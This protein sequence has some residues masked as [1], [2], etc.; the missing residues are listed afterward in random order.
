[1]R[2]HRTRLPQPINGLLATLVLFGLT[3]C[4]SSGPSNAKIEHDTMEVLKAWAIPYVT[5]DD[6]DV[7]KRREQA[8]DRV[9]YD[10]NMT[11]KFDQ[12][13]F[14]LENVRHPGT[15]RSNQQQMA[16]DLKLLIPRR[17]IMLTVV[18]RQTA[19]DFWELDQQA[20][21]QRLQHTGIVSKGQ[22]FMGGGLDGLLGRPGL[23]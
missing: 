23:Y 17:E 1:M 5:Q 7:V 2:T 6:F 8:E 13:A 3:A 18:Y 11:L 20:L 21:K 12:N 19:K 22:L 10:I 14:D 15:S 16:D 4:G 9:Q